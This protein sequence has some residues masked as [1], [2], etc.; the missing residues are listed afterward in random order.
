MFRPKA[1]NIV[2]RWGDG[3]LKMVSER[4][5]SRK[6]GTSPTRGRVAPLRGVDCDD[7]E[8]RAKTPEV[9]KPI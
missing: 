6:C 4:K 7:L 8:P 3:S 1:D 9:G 2:A 5:L